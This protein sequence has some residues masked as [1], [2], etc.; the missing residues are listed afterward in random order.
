MHEF[1]LEYNGRVYAGMTVTQLAEAGVPLSDIGKAVKVAAKLEITAFAESY[2]TKLASSS[3]GK[4]AEYRIKE[5]IA[6]N[7]EG[8]SATELELLS[9][10]AKA[11]GTNRTGLIAQINAQAAAY[12]QIA[13]L[14]GVLEAEAGAAISAI[15]VDAPDIEA[16]IHQV[17]TN[18]R[19]EAEAEYKN[20]LVLVGG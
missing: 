11:R 5:E 3:A 20:A 16:Q 15:A 7:P 14:I 13:L 18:V 4:L 19:V 12:R 6:G 2:R 10:E 17:L 8:A 9:R 1:T